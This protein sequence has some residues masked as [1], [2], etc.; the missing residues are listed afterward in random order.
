MPKGVIVLLNGVS[1]SGKTTIA[2]ELVKRLPG[3]FHF[4]IDDYDHVIE[5]M[6]DR[7][8]ER[9]IPVDTEIFFHRNIKMF[10]DY[11]LSLIVD[12]VL[13]NPFTL[14][15]FQS[16]LSDYPLLLIGVHCPAEILEQRE[17]TRGDRFAGLARRQLDLV[18]KGM[19]YDLEVNTHF[20]SL[21]YNVEL[22]CKRAR[23][24][25]ENFGRT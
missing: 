21:E 16:A 19:K 7:D 23:P 24:M 12:H 17:N 8:N 1:S 9:L 20:D 3:F 15:D 4:S 10:S 18:H 14:Q 11:G 13:H 25:V 2:R 5:K 6:E 22:I